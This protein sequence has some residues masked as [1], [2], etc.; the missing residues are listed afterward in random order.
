M[1]RAVGLQAVHSRECAAR[2]T[3]HHRR[4]TQQ[5]PLRTRKAFSDATAPDH[6]RRPLRLFESECCQVRGGV[7]SSRGRGQ[8]HVG[9]SRDR[10]VSDK[11]CREETE[12]RC[13]QWLEVCA[14]AVSC[15]AEFG[16]LAICWQQEQATECEG[17][18]E[19]G[20][21]TG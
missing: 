13:P 9:Q 2:E 21:R 1:S 16:Q 18:F 11:H 7:L 12:N 6:N 4:H 15:S 17:W 8:E 19:Q 3:R 10:A 14:R 20:Q 5:W